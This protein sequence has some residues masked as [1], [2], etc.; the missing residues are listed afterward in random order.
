[1]RVI[2]IN[3]KEREVESIKKYMFGFA[4]KDGVPREEPYVEVVIVGRSGRRWKE[5]WPYA[6]YKEKNPSSVV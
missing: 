1:M 3:D 4:D 2:D 6:V 5:W